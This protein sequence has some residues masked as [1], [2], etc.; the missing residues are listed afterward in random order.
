M[1]QGLIHIYCGDGK[2]KTT[3]CIGLAVRA[4]G[5]DFKVLLTQFLKGSPSGEL[6]SLAKIPNI[7]VLR[8]KICTK[9]TFQMT[10]EEKAE[11][12]AG[13]LE[14]FAKIEEKIKNEQIDMLILDEMMAAV[15]TGLFPLDRLIKFLKNKPA[16][17]EVIM[18]GREP[19]QELIDLADY[20][21]EVKMIKHPYTKG[22]GAR[23]GVER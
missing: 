7:E 18:S 9:F 12:L 11:T 23:D 10:P 1:Q 20:V 13:H 14:L 6:M 4:A 2:G 15:N 19:K 8:G 22:I 21:S 16:G 5:R 3:A 17:L